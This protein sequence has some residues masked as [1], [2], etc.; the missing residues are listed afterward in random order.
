VSSI[1][2]C[3]VCGR[4]ILAGERTRTYLSPDGE[5][6]LVCELCRSRAEHLGWVWEEEAGE[7]PPPAPRRRSGSLSSF[8]RGRAEQLRVRVEERRQREEAGGAEEAAPAEEEATGEPAEGAVAA[9]E[10]PPVRPRGS[11]DPAA[12]GAGVRARAPESPQT[13]LE[14]AVARFNASDEARTMAGLM[15][16]LG[17]PWISVGIAAG[18]PS[19]V[20]ITVAWELSWYQWGVDLR[21]ELRPVYQI[22]KGQ[23]LDEL[24]APAR[25]WNASAHEGG[26][27]MLGRA[28]SGEPGSGGP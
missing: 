28:P 22:D 17:Q 18:S 20:R 21:D 9:A 15:R 12:P 10:R 24:D 27:L 25:Q 19:E 14:R 7:L 26:Q 4:T 23:E 1:E 16:T 3:T 6:H 5:A 11:P 13:R 8:L 2:T